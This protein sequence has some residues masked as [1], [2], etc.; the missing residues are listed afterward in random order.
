MERRE[1]AYDDQMQ[2][3]EDGYNVHAR[4]LS[5]IPAGTT[6][7]IQD[8]VSKRWDRRGVVVLM[9][10]RRDYRIK[11]QSGRVYWRNRRFL[12]IDYTTPPEEPDP[13]AA[14]DISAG[15]SDVLSQET[16]IAPSP[17]PVGSNGRRGRKR[18]Q[19]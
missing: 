6:V 10:N 7:R 13:P 5:P 8:P 9:G 11:M 14:D 4:P 15:P 1:K 16:A 2:K 18:A 3:V 12:R 19:F 17:I